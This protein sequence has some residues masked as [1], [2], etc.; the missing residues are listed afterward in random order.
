[1]AT[2]T[3]KVTPATPKV[4]KP[5]ATQKSTPKVEPKVEPVVTQPEPKVQRNSNVLRNVMFVLIMI[6]AIM[7]IIWFGFQIRNQIA[8]AGNS[9]VINP[10][11]NDPVVNPV[12]NDPVVNPVG[13]DPVGDSV[14]ESTILVLGPLGSYHAVYDSNVQRWTL[15]IW[16]EAQVENGS[17]DLAALKTKGGTISFVMPFSGEVNNSAGSITVDGVNWTLGNPVRDANG[18]SVINK[19]QVVTINYGESNDSAGLQIWFTK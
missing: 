5:K 4:A 16:P 3:V 18:N 2:T 8:S 19:G 9:P 14:N 17:M 7:A 6:V 13:N 12:G 15:G 1:M 11:G 10:V